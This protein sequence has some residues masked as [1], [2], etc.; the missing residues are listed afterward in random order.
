M[1]AV[2]QISEAL[3]YVDDRFMTPEL[4]L[5]AVKR[6]GMVLQF[7]KGNRQ[8]PAVCMAAVQQYNEAIQCVVD[9]T[10]DICWEAVKGCPYMMKYIRDAKMRAMIQYR[11]DH[12]VL[13]ELGPT[14]QMPVF[15]S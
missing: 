9:Q 7:V 1:A 10:F 2:Q 14:F 5:F 8:T 11:L 12:P 13:I 15:S 3:K 6:H 4:C